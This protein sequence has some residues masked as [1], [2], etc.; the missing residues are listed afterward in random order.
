[1]TLYETYRSTE[2]RKQWTDLLRP[3]Y[4]NFNDFWENYSLEN[5]PEAGQAGNQ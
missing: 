4:M 1:M 3:E 5:D 2:F